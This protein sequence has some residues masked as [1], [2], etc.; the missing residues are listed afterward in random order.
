MSTM[1]N[2]I[3]RIL[4]DIECPQ[5]G[6]NV[7]E[8]EYGLSGDQRTC[9]SFTPTSNLKII[10]EIFFHGS[11]TMNNGRVSVPMYPEVTIVLTSNQMKTITIHPNTSGYEFSETIKPIL[12]ELVDKESVP[13]DWDKEKEP[14]EENRKLLQTLDQMNYLIQYLILRITQRKSA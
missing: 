8:E 12:L 7:K 14:S 10:Q 5:G 11:I 9:I 2:V 1:K 3:E 6:Y 13:P 4:R